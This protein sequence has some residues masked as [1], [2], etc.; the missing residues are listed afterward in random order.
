MQEY[1]FS[2]AR[3]LAYFI[4][5]ANSLWRSYIIKIM[6]LLF[7]LSTDGRDDK[8]IN[9]RSFLFIFLKQRKINNVIPVNYLSCQKTY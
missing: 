8:T 4:Q 9:N 5:C 3:I 1:G 2:T 6:L 7:R